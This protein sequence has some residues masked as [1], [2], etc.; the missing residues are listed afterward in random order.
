MLAAVV[1]LSCLLLLL[2]L[3]AG[4]SLYVVLDDLSEGQASL[5]RC[6]FLWWSSLLGGRHSAEE[7]S[8]SD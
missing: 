8:S 6:L 2:Y 1:V 4:I 3:A 7:D 5:W